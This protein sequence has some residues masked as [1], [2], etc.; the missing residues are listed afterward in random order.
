MAQ[1][2]F[3]PMISVFDRVKKVHTLAREATVIGST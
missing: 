2:G 3:E 1:M